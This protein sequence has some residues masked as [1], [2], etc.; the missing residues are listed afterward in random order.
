MAQ[1]IVTPQAR[2]D[3]EEAT[4][5]LNLPADAW[6]RIARSLRVLESFPLAGAEGG[7]RWSPT[8]FVLGPWPWMLMLYRHEESSDRVFVVAMHDARP[9]TSATASRA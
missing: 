2:R 6:R 8:R 4:A 3:V 5:A 1:I 9:A 7:G